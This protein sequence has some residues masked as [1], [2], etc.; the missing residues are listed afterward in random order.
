LK[1]FKNNYRICK[2]QFLSIPGL[3][4][5][6]ILS[7]NQLDGRPRSKANPEVKQFLKNKPESIPTTIEDNNDGFI[8]Q[9][10]GRNI[11]SL[12]SRPKDN[13]KL[14]KEQ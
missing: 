9:K 14:Q 3:P 2:V 1:K 6:W 8:T 11:T 12:E 10:I 4:N 7:F 13:E 5:A